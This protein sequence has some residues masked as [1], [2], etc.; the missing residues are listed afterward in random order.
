MG[1]QRLDPP[2]VT[3]RGRTPRVVAIARIS[4]DHQDVLSLDDQAALYRGWLEQHVGAKFKLTLLRSVES[5][6]RVDRRELKRL[7]RLIRQ[8]KVDLV[9]AEDLGRIVR[10]VHALLICEECEDHQTRL[11]AINDN[12][13]TARPDWRLSSMFASLRHETYNADTARRIRRTLRNR[14][15]QGGVFQIPLF[16]Y[17][18]PPGAKS[19]S[20]VKKRDGMEVIVDGIFSRLEGTH[21]GEPWFYA[22]VADWLHEQGAPLGPACRS[23]R[24]T[25]KMVQRI[26]VNPILKG[27]RVRNRKWSKRVNKTGRR[28]SVAAPAEELLE[29]SVPHL[30]FIE[31]TRY[32]RLIA[33]LNLRGEKYTVGRASGKDPRKGRPKKRTRF[34]GQQVFCGI[35][36]RVFVFGGHGQKDHLMCSGAREYKCWNAAT[37]DQGVAA[38]R[39]SAAIFTMLTELPD[40]DEQL[41]AQIH[42]AAD[43]LYS[44]ASDR[45]ARLQREIERTHTELAHITAAIRDAGAS[46]TLLRELAALEAKLLEL[47]AELEELEDE[48]RR[49]VRLPSKGEIIAAAEFEFEDLARTSFEF[50]RLMRRLAPRIEVHPVRLCDGGAILLRAR[51]DIQ[52]ESFLPK[53]SRQMGLAAHLRRSFQIDLFEPPQR[54][55]HRQAVEELRASGCTEREAARRLGITV[56]AAQKAALL[57]RLMKQLGI[58]DPYISLYEPPSDAGRFRRHLHPRYCF[59]PQREQRAA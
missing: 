16:C 44:Q 30:A 26:V 59:E 19:D 5:G 17:E 47:Q 8:D 23:K 28:R 58:E 57:G 40:F 36:G 41:I 6:E 27:V 43:E 4:T 31:S 53:S 51:F 45:R 20:E 14:F 29:R 11:I 15:A 35:C 54:A 49:C 37:F 1:I 42:A 33:R 46:P 34:P 32:D 22:A 25:G 3:R 39:I 56:T 10:R 55:A 21:D 50:A 7:R 13:D 48:P 9:L 18:K 38:E 12:I 2:L 24:W 52:L